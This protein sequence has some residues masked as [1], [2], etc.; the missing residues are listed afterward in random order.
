MSVNRSFGSY[1]ARSKLYKTN[2]VQIEEKG[3]E[4]RGL[5]SWAGGKNRENMNHRLNKTEFQWRYVPLK[6]ALNLDKVQNKGS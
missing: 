1:D 2:R 4:K 5:E 6:N 3:D